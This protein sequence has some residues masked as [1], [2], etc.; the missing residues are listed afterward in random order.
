MKDTMRGREGGR[1]GGGG[2]EG[3]GGRGKEGGERRGRR[4]EGKCSLLSECVEGLPVP[5]D[6]VSADGQLQQSL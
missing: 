1:E 4:E 5:A 2:R 6:G 3:E